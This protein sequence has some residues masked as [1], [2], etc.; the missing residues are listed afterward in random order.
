MLET[1]QMHTSQEPRVASAPK[2][3]RRPV[4]LQ[5]SPLSMLDMLKETQLAQ[6]KERKRSGVGKLF[7]W[8]FFLAVVPLIGIIIAFAVFL[9]LGGSFY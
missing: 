9:G 4:F 2:R 6:E 8:L 7:V 3:G 5:P 1:R